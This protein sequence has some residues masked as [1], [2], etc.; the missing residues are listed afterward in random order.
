MTEEHKQ[1][2]SAARKSYIAKTGIIPVPP[3]R[4][5]CKLSNEQ[6]EKIRQANFKREY[7]PL[8]KT[9]KKQISETLKRKY[10]SGEIKVVISEAQKEKLRARKGALSQSWRG[11]R[12]AE[13]ELLR[14]RSAWKHWRTAVFKRDN[15]TCQDCGQRGGIL[16]P[17]HIKEVA[18]YP[19][20]VYDISNGK[21]LC[22]SC[23]KK[24][25]NY[26][27]KAHRIRR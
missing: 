26:G 10:A 7:K 24:T 22:H 19:E 25:D 15:Y 20:L 18:N 2:I 16:E 11:G 14:K 13:K 27:Y 9:Q 8:T 4:K 5:G 6:K 21:T 23:H 12:T 3:S 17:H 1:K